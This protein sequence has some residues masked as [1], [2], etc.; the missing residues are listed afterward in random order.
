MSYAGMSTPLEM[1]PEAQG[2]ELSMLQRYIALAEARASGLA[3]QVQHSLELG[4]RNPH[5]SM[6]PGV[7]KLVW[8]RP[9][10]EVI[11][12][13]QLMGADL[14]KPPAAIT[15]T[16]ARD[17]KVMDPAVL[18]MYSQRTRAALQ[19]TRVTTTASRKVFGYGP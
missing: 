18:E 8:N 6:E 14:A 12:L 10:A 4:Q 15:P 3:E 7:S 19:L 13:G 9:D 11:A 2:L 16:Q 17:R 1:T 5:Y